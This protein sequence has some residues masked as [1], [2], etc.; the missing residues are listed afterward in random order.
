MSCY[1]EKALSLLLSSFPYV[2]Q[3]YMVVGTVTIR[4]PHIALATG[5]FVSE[6]HLRFQVKTIT[7]AAVVAAATYHEKSNRLL[8]A[9]QF[10]NR[11]GWLLS[12]SGRKINSHNA[13]HC[14]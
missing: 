1:R 3:V 4:V 6:K 13:V 7:H 5:P 12:T 10:A 9:A 14:D 11:N 8:H 2:A